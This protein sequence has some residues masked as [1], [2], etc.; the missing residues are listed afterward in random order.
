MYCKEPDAEGTMADD[1]RE[2]D[3]CGSVCT[4]SVSGHS[5]STVRFSG[6]KET[7]QTIRATCHL[8]LMTE[9]LSRLGMR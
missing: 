5:M 1:Q 4:S 9:R 8:R 6:C 3:V 2:L 7:Y